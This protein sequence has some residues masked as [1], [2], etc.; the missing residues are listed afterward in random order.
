MRAAKSGDVAVMRLLLAAGAD[1]KLTQ[2]N[3]A[4]ALMLAAGMGWRDGSPAAPS[5]DQGSEK[6]AIEA[7]KLCME[8]RPGH[9]RDDEH[10]R[11]RAA[12][13]D[14]RPRVG[15]RSCVSSS[16]MAPIS[17]RRTSRDARRSKSPSPVDASSPTSSTY[18]KGQDRHELEQLKVSKFKGQSW[19]VSAK[20]AG[21]AGDSSGA[22][23][24]YFPTF[25]FAL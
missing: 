21:R 24:T 10:R 22:L 3:Q 11:D 5:Y 18:L 23:W 1:P 12:R 15:N 25:T 2:P 8:R 6:D 20:Y 9:Q 19:E 14:L 4:N 17:R 7:I 13:R 16:R